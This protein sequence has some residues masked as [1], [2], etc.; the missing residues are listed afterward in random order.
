MR[1]KDGAWFLTMNF[2]F[3]EKDQLFTNL[4]FV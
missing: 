3:S 1:Y 4:L 2:R